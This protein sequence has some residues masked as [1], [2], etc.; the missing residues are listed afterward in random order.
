VA[1]VAPMDLVVLADDEGNS[2]R[3]K[4][5]GPEPT[6]SAGLAGEIVVET[7]FVSGRTSLILSASKLQAWGNAL[8]SLDAG[9]DIAWMAMDRGPSVFIQLTGDR[10][11]PEVVVEDES[12]S[13]VTVRVPIV[14]PGDWIAS[15]RRR[16]RALTDSW[17]PPQ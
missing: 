10:D 14:L 2:V 8:D 6:W 17:K 4:V 16:L 9:Q 3:I 13:M 5:L 1:D 7:P 15:H 11:C 12:Y